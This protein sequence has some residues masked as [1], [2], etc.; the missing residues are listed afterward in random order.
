MATTLPDLDSLHCFVTAARLLNF[1]AAAGSV[2][3][4]P[5]AL[6]KRIKSL[7]EDLGVTL[8]HRTTRHVALSEEGLRLLPQAQGV[9]LSA[10]SL[11]T[12]ARG[13]AGLPSMELNVGTRHELGISWIIPMLPELKVLLPRVTFHLYF[14]SGADLEL[15]VRTLEIDCA[16]SSRTVVDPHVD[17]F[18]LHTEAYTFVAAPALLA[19]RPL[20]TPS[21]AANHVLIDAHQELPLLR[22]Y[23]DAPDGDDRIRFSSAVRIGTIAGIAALVRS[24]DG[25]AVLPTYFVQPF[26]DEGSLTAVFPDVGL[27]TDQ[28]RLLFRRDDPRRTVYEAVAGA[29]LQTPLQ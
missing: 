5:A 1:R 22:Y 2:G 19:D 11:V 12:D 7:E 8:F 27:L 9:L 21:D 10:E 29:M 16:V 28:F 20:D 3:L 6:G 25:V 13:N 26:L 17:H 14:G 18:N 4:T 23:R 24:G 15:R